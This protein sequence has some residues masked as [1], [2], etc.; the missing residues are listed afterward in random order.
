METLIFQQVSVATAEGGL[1]L[2]QSEALRW[3]QERMGPGIRVLPVER[4]ALAV[5]L[6]VPTEGWP[7]SAESPAG[8]VIFNL[9]RF[10]ASGQQDEERGE[11]KIDVI[12]VS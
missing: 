4:S 6:Q 3:L 7:T 9:H 5:A 1:Q 2:S 8:K 11:W 10:A 12:S